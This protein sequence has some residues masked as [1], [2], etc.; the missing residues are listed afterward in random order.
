MKTYLL[1]WNPKRWKWTDIEAEGEQIQQNGFI[2][3]PWSCGRN[4]GIVEGDRLFLLRQ[5]LEP[6]GIVASGWATS[7][8]FEDEH[9]D[10][11]SDKSTAL[12]IQARFDVLL[13][14]DSES[15]Y[16]RQKLE[17]GKFVGASS[18]HWDSQASG[19]TIPAD[20]AAILEKEWAAFL[21]KKN[22]V[23]GSG[24]PSV[25][26]SPDEVPNNKNYYEG[27]TK[28]VR[29]NV[30]ERNDKAR[31]DCINHY[32]WSC[33]ICGFDFEEAYGEMGIGFIHV[34]HLKPLSEIGEEYQVD[35]IEDLRPVCPNCHAMIHSRK[36]PHSIEEVK[37]QLRE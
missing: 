24:R 37:Q 30:Y 3:E 34:H 36:Q 11:K 16:P 25:T 32:G 33:C 5:G 20:V 29:V 13:N 9:F 22:L 15:I 35:P 18:M 10:P 19:I 6:R 23:Q 26:R 27:A 4:K 31:L 21:V 8:V 12:Y 14:P 2:E 1:T 17:A 28:S 7:D